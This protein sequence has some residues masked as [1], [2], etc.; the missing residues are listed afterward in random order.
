M[1]L[2]TNPA[3]GA[4]PQLAANLT[5]VKIN[6][7]HT[8]STLADWD[9]DR[10]PRVGVPVRQSDG[11]PFVDTVISAIDADGTIHLDLP[12]YACDVRQVS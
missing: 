1:T 2:S 12:A 11:G 4:P 5:W 9:E 7:G 10:D 6:G 3:Q 8:T